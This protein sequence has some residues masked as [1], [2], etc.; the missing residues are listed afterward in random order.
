MASSRYSISY[1]NKN[2]TKIKEKLDLVTNKLNNYSHTSNATS[3]NELKSKAIPLQVWT[4]P[5]GSS[6]LRLPQFL[7]SRHM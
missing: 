5:E 3:V 1:I 2:N 7:H 6:R 4:G